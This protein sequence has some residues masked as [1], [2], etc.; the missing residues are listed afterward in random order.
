MQETTFLLRQRLPEYQNLLTAGWM[1]AAGG[2]RGLRLP[3]LS[4]CAF[5]NAFVTSTHESHLK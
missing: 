1:E 5:E 2:R 4:L 3:V